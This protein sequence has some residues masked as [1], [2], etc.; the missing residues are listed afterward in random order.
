MT[1]AR[2]QPCLR[3]LGINLGYHNAKAIWHRYIFERIKGLFL[4]NNHFCLLWKS[5]SIRFNRVA[6]ELTYNSKIIDSYVLQ[7]LSNLTLNIYTLI[8]KLNHI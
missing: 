1:M 3:K 7:K 4:H 2:N 6:K 5:E 8:K